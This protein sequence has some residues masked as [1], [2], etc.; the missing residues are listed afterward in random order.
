[1]AVRGMPER[2]LNLENARALFTVRSCPRI[3]HG[4]GGEVVGRGER[5]DP[6]ARGR[7]M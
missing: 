6:S 5:E 1:M 2:C 7:A 3:G 4:L